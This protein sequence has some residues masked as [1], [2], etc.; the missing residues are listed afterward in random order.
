MNAVRHLAVC[1]SLLLLLTACPSPQPQTLTYKNGETEQQEEQM[2]MLLQLNQH[3]A[4]EADRQ[5]SRFVNAGY[6]Q[7]E[8][9]CWVCGLKN[10]DEP[11]R[12][13][14]KT[15]VWIRVYLLDGTLVEDIHRTMTVGQE[16][17]TQA[18]ADL[19]PEMPRNGKVSMLV[20]WYIGYGT[21][22]SE[23]IP[24]Y[25]NMRMEIQTGKL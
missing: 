6:V 17:T 3:M 14:D 11:L 9:G 22:G 12:N 21:V 2:A 4:E 25:T 23:H 5:L 20:P 7:M 15:D 24:P 10:V 18:V 1:L 8:N 19:L 13:G 16:Q